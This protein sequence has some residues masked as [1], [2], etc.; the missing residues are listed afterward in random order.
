MQGYRITIKG[1]VQGVGYRPFVY[2][3]AQR[4]GIWGKVY[5]TAQGVIVECGGEFADEFIDELKHSHP[6]LAQVHSFSV[7]TAEIESSG[8]FFIDQSAS[9][10]SATTLLSP[11]IAICEACKQELHESSSRRFCYPFINCTDCGPRYSIIKALPYDRKNTA[12]QPFVMCDACKEEYNDPASRMFHAQPV[13]C[14]ECGVEVRL[15]VGERTFQQNAIQKCAQ[16]IQSGKIGAIKGVG[17][18]HLV[19]DATNEAALKRLRSYKSRPSKPFALMCKDLTQVQTLAYV[20]KEEAALL[21]SK[22]A[23]IVLLQKREDSPVAQEVAPKISR[24]GCMVASTPLHLLLFQHLDMPIVATSANLGGE[25]IVTT[26]EMVKTKLPFVEFI[27]DY[28]RDILNPID[29]SV[30]QLVDGQMM[31][32]RG[33]RGF[34]PMYIPLERELHARY[35]ATGANQK[36][37]IALAFGKSMVLS[38][39]IA[40]LDSVESIEH[41]RNMIANFKRFYDFEYDCVVCDMH[42]EYE[43][44]KIAHE[45]SDTPIAVQHHKAHLNAVKAEY[46]LSGDAFC[47]FIFDGTGYGEDGTLWGGE[48]FV[49]EKRAYRF[50]PLRLLGGEKAIKECYRVAL[51]KLFESHSL[52]EVLE[53]KLD[54]VQRHK[55]RIPLL[56]TMYERELNAPLSSSVGRLFDMV[57]AFANLCDEQSYEGEAGLL[58]ESVYDASCKE[59]FEFVIENGEIEIGF[60]YDDALLV[61]KFMN[62]L[63]EII[64]HIAKKEALAV[65][66]SGGVFQNKTLCE[67]LSKRLKEEAIPYYMN[68]RIPPNDSG[69]SIGQLYTAIEMRE[70]R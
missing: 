48:V 19:C 28:N 2:A 21:Q 17:G 34:M 1:V 23:P 40:D 20:S 53:L 29:D 41:F 5:N 67:L 51:A 6:P 55:K 70:R 62:T 58:C 31:I 66:L 46:G 65:L 15:Y 50:K 33:A 27:L 59:H 57:A 43:S 9:Q 26:K 69:V 68:R 32:L 36:S 38:P 42:P 14:N 4:L 11:D 63:V 56:Y 10:E 16:L 45:L 52:S 7:E 61:T 8:G 25:P 37:T 49:G 47:A 35:L 3:L 44:T 22:E 60:V 24:I 64:V 54:V 18:F 12:M 39:Y 30:V 13:G